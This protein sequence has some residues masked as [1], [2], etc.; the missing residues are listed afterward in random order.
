VLC[1]E[2]ASKRNL[3]WFVG[4]DGVNWID[5]LGEGHQMAGGIDHFGAEGSGFFDPIG[6]LTGFNSEGA[7]R[8]STAISNAEAITDSEGN[9]CYSIT[10]RTS[11]LNGDGV[12]TAVQTADRVILVGHTN[13]QGF[14]TGGDVVPYSDL[15][16]SDGTQGN[17]SI[18]GCH[19]SP[20]G[21]VSQLGVAMQAIEQIEALE[22]KE[23]CEN[24]EN[25]FV[26]SGTL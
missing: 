25:I 26:E 10:L 9:Q 21:S 15:S 12:E 14:H 6:G 18:H 19:Q 1:P 20:S 13:A 24:L 3:Y 5:S 4:N 11:A 17:C 16:G 2:R 8:L 22:E 23:C 7:S